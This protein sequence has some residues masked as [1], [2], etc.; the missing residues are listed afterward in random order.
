MRPVDVFSRL[1]FGR[2]L[3][4]SFRVAAERSPNFLSPWGSEIDVH[5][6][7][8]LLEQGTFFAEREVETQTVR[9]RVLLER[10]D[11]SDFLLVNESGGAEWFNKER[12]EA[13][14]LMLY[15]TASV[16]ALHEKGAE[17]QMSE[18]IRLHR[19]AR[20]LTDDAERA[21]YRMDIFLQLSASG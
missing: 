9:A 13:L 10:P 11:V 16:V 4:A 5:I 2:V 3:A 6:L 21:G 14:I 12:F 7:K 18:I 17:V 8:L 15:L 20:K 19:A 1:G